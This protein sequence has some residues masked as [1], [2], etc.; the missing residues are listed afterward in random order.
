MKVKKFKAL[1]FRIPCDLHDGVTRRA[2]KSGRSINAELIAI[3]AEAL[4]GALMQEI[5]ESAVRRAMDG[6]S[7]RKSIS[8]AD[9]A[10]R[11]AIKRLIAGQVDA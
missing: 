5:V 6:G 7:S 9:W 3:V 4:A 2:E 1:Q 10:E 8:Y 11:P